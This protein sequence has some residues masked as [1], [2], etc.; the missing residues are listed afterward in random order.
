M[1]RT[2]SL[3]HSFFFPTLSSTNLKHQMISSHKS[4]SN[5]NCINTQQTEPFDQQQPKFKSCSC[6]CGGLGRRHFIGVSSG[7]L[8]LPTFPSFASDL[9][10]SHSKDM[11]NRIHPPKPDW[12]EEFFALAME[13]SMKSYEAEIAGYKAN[14][15]TELRG[16]S[17]VL[18]L[19][20]GT[21]PNLSYYAGDGDVSV[22]GIDP[23]K[24]MEKYA[25]E[26]A[27]SAG[28]SSSNFIFTQ[29]VA[30]ALP[31]NDASMDAVIGTLVLCSVKDIQLALQEVKRVL[32]PGGLYI[33]IEH[34]AAKDGTTLRLMQ[35][36]FDPLQQLVSDGCHLTRETGKYISQAG[37]SDININ[38][39]YLSNASLI[40]P[41]V[42]GI[43]SK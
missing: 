17:K 11:L 19:G 20:I 8:L 27:A 39:T 34:V 3:L 16:K 12:Y 21:G 31:V 32:K 15:F 5:T 36:V 37:F 35:K 43:A 30:E 6:S 22:F 33:F 23:N 9:L 26:A 18:E 29:A 38:M 10:P 40:S 7:A 24:R 1:M 2:C 41:H 13:K 28:L 25:Q 14:L 4:T 42:Y